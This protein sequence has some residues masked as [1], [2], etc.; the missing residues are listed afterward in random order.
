MAGVGGEKTGEA[1]KIADLSSKNS[2]QLVELTMAPASAGLVR[3]NDLQMTCVIVQT[4]TEIR[5]AQEARS[6]ATTRAASG[7]LGAVAQGW[8]KCSRD[9]Q[10]ELP[11]LS[12]RVHVPPHALAS[13]Q[14]RLQA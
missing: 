9:D 7:V 4:F 5:F 6:V 2:V 13:V 1:D 14:A 3:S 10:V 11:R 12:G 8:D